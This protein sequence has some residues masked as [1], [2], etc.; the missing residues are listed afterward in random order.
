[1]LVVL[2]NILLNLKI[3][4][5][6]KTRPKEDFLKNCRKVKDSKIGEGDS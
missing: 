5:T 6:Q 4:S 2:L 1:M 3:F